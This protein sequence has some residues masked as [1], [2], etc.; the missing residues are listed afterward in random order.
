MSAR[1][2]LDAKAMR[3]ARRTLRK[4]RIPTQCD[5][6]GWMKLRSNL[7]TTQCINVALSGAL[8]VDSHTIGI[9]KTPMGDRFQRIVP[10][11]MVGPG[12]SKIKVVRPEILRDAD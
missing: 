9:R 11:S 1:N 4:G 8:R 2:R 10:T 3:R 7:T 6:I 12:G 5:L